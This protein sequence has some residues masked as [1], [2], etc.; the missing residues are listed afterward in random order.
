MGSGRW[1]Q[2][3]TSGP[4]EFHQTVWCVGCNM[5]T[6]FLLVKKSGVGKETMEK[7][8]KHSKKFHEKTTQEI[9]HPQF[10]MGSVCLHILSAACSLAPKE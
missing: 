7:K 10:L 2:S 4:A 3:K 6:W 8:T 1:Q 5:P 9:K